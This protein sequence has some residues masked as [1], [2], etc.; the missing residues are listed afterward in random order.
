M[1]RKKWIVVCLSLPL[2]YAYADFPGPNCD[3]LSVNIVNDVPHYGDLWQHFAQVESN[4][5]IN[6]TDD[7]TVGFC[8]KGNVPTT[9]GIT[10]LSSDVVKFYQAVY[11]P[12]EKNKD[13]YTLYA[14]QDQDGSHK[15]YQVS[16]IDVDLSKV[17]GA[18]YT[19]R[20]S[21]ACLYPNPNGNGDCFD[22]KGK[23]YAPGTYLQTIPDMVH[24]MK[25]KGQHAFF[26][27]N[28]GYD[29]RIDHAGFSDNICLDRA[30]P[31][32]GVDQVGDNY[33]RLTDGDG[34]L[35][36]QN[37]NCPGA[38]PD[39]MMAQPA[40]FLNG[41]H[42]YMSFIPTPDILVY[43]QGDSVQNI[44]GAGPMLVLNNEYY[45]LSIKNSHGGGNIAFD[46]MEIGGAVAVGLK[47]DQSGDQHLYIVAVAGDDNNYGMN[48]YMLSIFM[49]EVL[50]VDSAMALGNGGDAT[51]WVGPTDTPTLFKRDQ[52]GDV[53]S[54]NGGDTPRTV[55][56][57]L[58]M[59]EH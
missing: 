36:L 55:Y 21:V 32:A 48:N 3:S 6:T 40:L 25:A 51:L 54:G 11:W 19:I 43:Q 15:G 42:S 23:A 46:D 34:K 57:G 45:L 16:L 39:S 27:V 5:I 52:V 29:Y 26:G 49:K 44:L 35:I 12:Y 22:A 33:L 50:N 37:P 41:N 24:D 56:D 13:I 1:L 20:P 9:I 59:T 10:G 38:K 4:N 14:I 53:M 31:I 58:F 7:N 30:K 18:S 47:K 17:A 8:Y 2:T 28:G